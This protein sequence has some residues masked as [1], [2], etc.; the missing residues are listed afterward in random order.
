LEVLV[1]ETLLLL[2]NPFW[3]NRLG[4][5]S[6]TPCH[7][8]AGSLKGFISLPKISGMQTEELD[9]PGGGKAYCSAGILSQ[10]TSSGGLEMATRL[11][12]GRINGFP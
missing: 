11:E 9:P 5:Y 10:I 3:A 4:V 12:F 7:Y 1:F 6:N 2:I 8:E